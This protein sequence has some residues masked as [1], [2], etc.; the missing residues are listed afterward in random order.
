MRRFS[1]LSFGFVVRMTDPASTWIVTFSWRRSTGGYVMVHG[2]CGVESGN[3]V[4]TR[5]CRGGS[6][7]VV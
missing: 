7:C 2:P 3:L 5:G 6:L 4:P 1:S